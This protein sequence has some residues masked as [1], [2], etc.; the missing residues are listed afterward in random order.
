MSK[1]R[2]TTY[3]SNAIVSD[4]RAGMTISEISRRHQVAEGTVHRVLTRSK[5]T[6][7]A[8]KPATVSTPATINKSVGGKIVAMTKENEMLR[9]HNARLQTQVN[10][11]HHI[12]IQLPSPTLVSL[13]LGPT[14]ASQSNQNA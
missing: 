11:L 13:L 6:T 14:G 4:R 5:R 10:S 8:A 12:L 2:N 3:D 1:E 9:T 7:T